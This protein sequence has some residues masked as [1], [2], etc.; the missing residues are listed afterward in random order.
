MHCNLMEKPVVA[1][2]LEFH[3]FHEPASF[4]SLSQR[5]DFSPY[6]EPD[7]ASSHLFT[8]SL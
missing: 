7:E 5:P 6:R 2:L 1:H 4:I 8:A 3:E